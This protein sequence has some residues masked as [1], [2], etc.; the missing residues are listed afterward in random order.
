MKRSLYLLLIVGFYLGSQNRIIG[1]PN[2]YYV[3]AGTHETW[4]P[5]NNPVTHITGISTTSIQAKN[6]IIEAGGILDI[7]G[8]VIHMD[9][10]NHIDIM[11]SSSSSTFIGGRLNLDHSTLTSFGCANTSMWGGVRVWGSP[12]PQLYPAVSHQGMINMINGSTISWAHTA[13]A[14]SKDGVGAGGGGIATVHHGCQFLDNNVGIYFAPYH[15][16]NL[17]GAE[18]NNISYVENSIFYT[19]NPSCAASGNLFGIYGIDVKGVSV[20]GCSFSNDAGASIPSAGI[21][22]LDMGM[23]VGGY[24]SA[25]ITAPPSLIP[26]T[27][28]GY[29]YGIFQYNSGSS[30]TV[31]VNG[32]EFTNNSVG[33]NLV[34]TQFPVILN[35]KF[36]I[37]DLAPGVAGMITPYHSQII[38]LGLNLVSANHFQVQGNL[39]QVSPTILPWVTTN[40]T[41]GVLANNTINSYDDNII[42]NNTYHGTY[43]AN[44]ANYFNHNHGNEH[45]SDRGLWYMCNNIKGNIM[46]I[47][48]TGNDTTDGIRLS[49][50]YL[51]GSPDYY[52]GL[53]AANLFSSS[54]SL[55]VYN[56]YADHYKSQPI[57]YLYA[58]PAISPLEIPGAPPTTA[59]IYSAGAGPTTNSNNCLTLSPFHDGTISMHHRSPVSIS[60]ISTPVDKQ[61]IVNF[62]INYYM[63]DENGIPHR[64]SLYYWVNQLASGSAK[65]VTAGLLMEDGYNDSA[66]AIY[67]NIL[68]T[69]PL[70]SRLLAEYTTWGSPLM[71]IECNIHAWQNR[72]KNDILSAYTDSLNADSVVLNDST[73][74]STKPLGRTDKATLINI[75]LGS[76]LWPHFIAE[77]ILKAYC[78]DTFSVLIA[79]HPDTLLIPNRPDSLLSL[80]ASAGVLAVTEISQGPE[81]TT[82][83]EYAEMVVSNCGD[84]AFGHVDI[85]GWI[86][87]D[88]AGNFDTSG[89]S[90]TGITRGH[91]RL[92]PDGTGW[93]NMPVGS[94]IVVYN[95]DVNCYNLPDTFTIDTAHLVFWLPVHSAAISFPEGY[96]FERYDGSAS[97]DAGSYCSDEGPTI[98]DPASAWAN[99]ISLA[100]QD[101]VQVRCPGCNSTFSGTPP[102]YQGIGYTTGTSSCFRDIPAVP[103]IGGP[104]VYSPYGN[105]KYVFMGSAV[106]DF[107]DASKWTASAADT[108]GAIPATLGNVNS[109]LY[110][111]I[112]SSDLGLPCCNYSSRGS[113]P[114]LNTNPIVKTSAKQNQTLMVYPNPATM[115]ISFDFP[116]ADETTIKLMDVTG[117]LMDQ[118]VILG[119][120]SIEFEV[121]AYSPGVYLY[122]IITGGK[123]Q[124]GK[125][126]V[127]K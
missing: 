119:G 94:K 28:Y 27:F 69:E 10:W 93:K 99:T 17:A 91:Y 111:A 113:V 36:Y 100:P 61:L 11:N 80:T 20:I 26:S 51:S 85:S 40:Y 75:F 108:A 44:L 34:G 87:D 117:R 62:N 60:A 97:T 90:D 29:N 124:T 103:G 48:T 92:S 84:D 70:S 2:D 32:A 67:S 125:I 83:C 4:T 30:N 9:D 73:L 53:P 58:N 122:Q 23:N 25:P 126:L 88:N 82:G 37:P 116:I 123:T 86:I 8:L 12:I 107:A 42:N 49:Q 31:Y 64:D 5:T 16:Y 45:F 114:G 121:H 74:Q 13:I 50:G 15:N 89:C 24:N 1:M 3:L 39:F 38:S 46:D 78:P 79:A 6:I 54:S 18:M 63:N 14:L 118:K 43:Y 109:D 59:Q 21:L 81:G 110:N 7:Q 35:N 120:S 55:L 33:I 72:L 19:A 22:G 105:Q 104:V 56:L 68:S 71:A 77:S 57:L 76:E 112:I 47:A 95:A 98:Y 66:M 96:A 52:A 65:L 115:T 102:F 106:N 41:V 101:A 127:G